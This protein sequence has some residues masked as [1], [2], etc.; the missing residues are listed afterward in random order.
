[1][2]YEELREEIEGLNPE[3][4][5]TKAEK[6]VSNLCRSGGKTWVLSVPVKSTDPDMILSEVIRRL[7]NYEIE[8]GN[9]DQNKID[10]YNYD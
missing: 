6:I 4:L 8:R 7:K 10:C 2:T 5:I 3:Y 9:F 1:M